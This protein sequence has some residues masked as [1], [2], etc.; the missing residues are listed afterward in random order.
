MKNGLQLGLSSTQTTHDLSPPPSL[1][2]IYFFFRK[3]LVLAVWDE[4]IL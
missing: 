1:N 4:L 2:P 3:L